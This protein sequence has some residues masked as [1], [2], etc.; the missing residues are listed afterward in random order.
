MKCA[1]CKNEFDRGSYVVYAGLVYCDDEC[2]AE[3]TVDNDLDVD[4]VESKRVEQ[5][6]IP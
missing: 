6:V 4:N 5:K 3:F 1:N 2:L